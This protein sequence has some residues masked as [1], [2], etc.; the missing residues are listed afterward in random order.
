MLIRRPD[1]MPFRDITAEADYVN[2]RDWLAAVGMGSLALTMPGV[3]QAAQRGQD[4]DELTPYASIT[5]YNNFYEFGT[6]KEE[7][8]ENAKG[9]VTTPWTVRVEGEVKRPATYALDDLLKGVPVVERT[10][11]HRCVEAWSMVIPWMGV[12][13]GALLRKLEPTSRAKFVE[14]TTLNDPKRMPGQT[15]PVLDWPYV[16]AIRIDE[17]MHPLAMLATGIYGK[18]ILPQNGAPIRL[19]VPWKYGFKGG[20]SLVK[21]RLTETMPKTTW[22]IAIPSEY[23]FY[24]NVNPDV[25]HPRWS[26]ARERRVGEFLRR[27]TLPFNGYAKEVASLYAGMDLRA[28]Y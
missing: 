9:F 10:Y 24:A 3:A 12:P 18:K 15:R 4:D 1:D 20:K 25:S 5:T 11:R 22:N 21:I 14:F 28:N 13:L 7:P 23:G 26:Q 8:A 27:K 19:V 16:E 17:A 6:G 2:R